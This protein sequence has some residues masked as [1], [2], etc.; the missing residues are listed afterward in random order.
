LLALQHVLF[1]KKDKAGYEWFVS[2]VWPKKSDSPAL[3]YTKATF[4]R[5]MASYH[6][7]LCGTA[8]PCTLAFPQTGEAQPF[9]P[10][11]EKALL[12]YKKANLQKL[13]ADKSIALP[14][15]VTCEREGDRKTAAV[16]PATG[17]EYDWSKFGF[18]GHGDE[19]KEGEFVITYDDGPHEEFTPALAQMWVDSGLGKP[20]FFW[21]A[22]NFSTT[23]ESG[24]RNIALG[25]QIRD[26][27]FEIGCHSRNHA[28]IDLLSRAVSIDKLGKNNST[29][30]AAELKTPP[31]DFIAWRLGHLDDEVYNATTEIYKKLEL[32]IPGKPLDRLFR[33]PGGVGV[34]QPEVGKALAKTHARHYHWSIDSLDFQD[35]S[36]TSIVDRVTKLMEQKKKGIILFHDIH[37]QSVQASRILIER[38]KKDPKIKF[39]NLP[40]FKPGY[41]Y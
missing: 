25:R 11:D 18:T 6:E 20:T 26:A 32:D 1:E 7:R 3:T 27:G 36:A 14:S 21:L 22:R 38:W 35:P 29:T 39:V 12:T 40:R 30:F 2:L 10:L 8:K 5:H 19:L 16:V 34:R 37:P 13:A 33:L 9:S 31:T 15:P 17:K 23:S 41:E 28:N 4:V 24:R